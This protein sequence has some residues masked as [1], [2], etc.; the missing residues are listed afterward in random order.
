MKKD[1]EK[2]REHLRK[3]GS[4]G[5]KANFLKRG[6]TGMKKISHDYW[7]STKKDKRSKVK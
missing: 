7:N 3:I 4:L 1:S 6:S 5:G 2:F